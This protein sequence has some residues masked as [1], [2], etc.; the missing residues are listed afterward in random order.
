MLYITKP[1]T[2]LLQNLITNCCAIDGLLCTKIISCVSQ[3]H[4]VYMDS[5][6]FYYA[7]KQYRLLENKLLLR[8]WLKDIT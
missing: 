5:K 1:E 7:P 4:L 6:H 2:G 3:I 8:L